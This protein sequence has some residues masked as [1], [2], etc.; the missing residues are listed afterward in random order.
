M[1]QLLAANN[2]DGVDWDSKVRERVYVCMRV[3]LMSVLLV[4]FQVASKNEDAEDGK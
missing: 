4:Y 3:M 1:E 2:A